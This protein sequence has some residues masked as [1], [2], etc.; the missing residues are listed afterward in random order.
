MCADALNKRRILVVEDEFF[1][2]VD[3]CDALQA[4]GAVVIGPAPSVDKALSLIADGSVIDAALLDVDLG[5]EMAYPVADTLLAHG[6]PFVFTTG[7]D[8]GTLRQRY[9]AVPR[10]EKPAE[11]RMIAQAL[12][13]AMVA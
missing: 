5:G 4:A 13:A 8:D 10:C 12:G 2:M 3:L 11:F 9:P 7:Y 6:I 1:V